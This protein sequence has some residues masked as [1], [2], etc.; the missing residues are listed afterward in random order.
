MFAG[1]ILHVYH[2]PSPGLP[3]ALQPNGDVEHDH[4]PPEAQLIVGLLQQ[5]ETR[6][7]CDRHVIEREPWSIR[8]YPLVNCGKETST[9]QFT[10]TFLTT[11]FE[12]APCHHPISCLNANG[13]LQPSRAAPTIIRLGSSPRF[14]QKI[15][16]WG[17]VVRWLP[18]KTVAENTHDF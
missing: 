15:S 6:D 3:L 10:A 11:K 5:P 13:K 2:V 16:V 1:H 9:V 18:M 12:I 8:I 4:I 7:F 17:G 14:A